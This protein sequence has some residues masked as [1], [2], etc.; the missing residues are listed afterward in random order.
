MPETVVGPVAF[1]VKSE[2]TA[3]PPLSFVT[4]LLRVRIGEI[5]LSLMVQVEVWPLAKVRFEPESVPAVQLHA[6]AV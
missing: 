6:P 3:A 4:V 5:S 2:T 1:K